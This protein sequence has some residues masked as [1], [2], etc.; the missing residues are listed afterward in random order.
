MLRECEQGSHWPPRDWT[1]CRPGGCAAGA[2]WRHPDH[3]RRALIFAIAVP[4]TV[5]MVGEKVQV[6]A[7]R[8]REGPGFQG[9]VTQVTFDGLWG[10]DLRRRPGFQELGKFSEKVSVH[11]D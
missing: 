2:S 1:G 10:S 3:S 8:G 7:L 5:I 9:G 11:L 6:R 4:R